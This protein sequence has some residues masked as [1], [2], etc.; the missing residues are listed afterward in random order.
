MKIEWGGWISHLD[1]SIFIDGVVRR[2]TREAW[3]RGFEHRWLWSARFSLEK[4]CDGMLVRLLSGSLLV[5]EKKTFLFFQH[6]FFGFFW[7]TSSLSVL[8][9][10]VMSPPS[11]LPLWLCRFK[12]PAPMFNFVVVLVLQN[13]GLAIRKFYHET[14]L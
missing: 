8:E 7:E 10:A 13:I 6:D 4:S 3:G 2:Q 5:F 12:K 1:T 14:M 9:P 11:S